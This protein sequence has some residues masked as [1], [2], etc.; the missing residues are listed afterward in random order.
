MVRVVSPRLPKTATGHRRGRAGSGI[1]PRP[2]GVAAQT[3]PAKL[4]EGNPNALCHQISPNM[5][6]NPP[7]WVALRTD[8][9]IY[10]VWVAGGIRPV[11][12]DVTSY[13]KL[14]MLYTSLRNGRSTRGLSKSPQSSPHSECPSRRQRFF[15]SRLDNTHGRSKFPM[16]RLLSARGRMPPSLPGGLNAPF[17]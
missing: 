1:R 6:Y 2:V 4:G 3:G 14:A 9:I 7:H 10:L 15:K 8:S 11:M 16:D 13:A 17:A 12:A 5:P